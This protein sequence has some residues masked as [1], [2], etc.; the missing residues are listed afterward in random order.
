MKYTKQYLKKKLR[1]LDRKLHYLGLFYYWN[2]SFTDGKN[3]RKKLDLQRK[4]VRNKIK[5]YNRIGN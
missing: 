5:Y 4:E 1:E 2:C 3:E